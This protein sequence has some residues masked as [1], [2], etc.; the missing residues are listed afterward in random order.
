MD[1]R[2]LVPLL[3]AFLLGVTSAQ[4]A[5]GKIT[6]TSPANNATVS[7]NDNVELSY[8]AVPGPDGDH[9]HLYLDDKR[10]D[11]LH[12]MKGKADVG[13]LDPGKHRICLSINTRG[14][15]ATGVEQCIDVISK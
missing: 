3:F 2:I 12:P 7:Q 10:I 8:E 5:P 15:V 6:I 9:L 1:I 14:H 11:V 4:A 13:M